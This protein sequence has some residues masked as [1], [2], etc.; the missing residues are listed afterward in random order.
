M[1]A[2]AG[3]THHFTSY[4]KRLPS[5]RQAAD[6]NAYKE[7][8]LSSLFRYKNRAVIILSTCPGRMLTVEVESVRWGNWWNPGRRRIS[9]T[10]GSVGSAGRHPGIQGPSGVYGNATMRSR[11][12]KHFGWIGSAKFLFRRLSSAVSAGRN[13]ILRWRTIADCGADRIEMEHV[14]AVHFR[15]WD[16]PLG[17]EEKGEL[18]ATNDYL[19]IFQWF[20]IYT[21]LVRSTVTDKFNLQSSDW[22]L[23]LLN[24]LLF[25]SLNNTERAHTM[26]LTIVHRPNLRIKH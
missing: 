9:T 20:K 13:P 8:S 14:R 12:W 11:I 17:R 15:A 16:K 18:R 7:L 23:P 19:S 10:I 6:N 2:T 1:T 5:P 4:W 3:W 26:S 24:C 21:S 25:N 22:R